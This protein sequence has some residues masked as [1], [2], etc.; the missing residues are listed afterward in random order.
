MQNTATYNLALSD[1]EP[2]DAEDSG[3]S[4]LLNAAAGQSADEHSGSQCHGEHAAE[5][6][7]AR[8]GKAAQ[9]DNANERFRNAAEAIATTMTAN[10]T[11]E[12]GNWENKV[13]IYCGHLW[14]G[15]HIGGK[16]ERIQVWKVTQKR[17]GLDCLLW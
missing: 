1:L 6:E 5:D 15:A 3:N 13:D 8:E 10:K 2:E 9:R 14:F 17:L 11:D 16:L 12:D 4:I 7:A